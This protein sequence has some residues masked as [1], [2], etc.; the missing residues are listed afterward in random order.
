[1]ESKNNGILGFALGVAAVAVTVYVASAAWK[2]GAASKFA[3]KK[4]TP[5]ATETATETDGF[6]GCAG[7]DGNM[8]NAAGSPEQ[9]KTCAN[10]SPYGCW[11]PNAAGGCSLDR[12]CYD[13]SKGTIARRPLYASVR[14][15]YTASVR[16]RALPTL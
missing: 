8:S 10:M 4:A 7:C 5:P 3:E 2:R 15:A 12:K 9:I 14:P 11:Y 16:S 6:S 13:K 1:M